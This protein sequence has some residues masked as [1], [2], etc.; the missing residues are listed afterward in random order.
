MLEFTK[1]IKA[2]K[3]PQ[4][5]SG[6][7]LRQILSN[8]IGTAFGRDHD[9]KSI[10]DT[11]DDEE[12]Y[13]RYVQNIPPSEYEAFRPYVDRSLAGE[14]DILFPG[15]PVMY[16]TTSGT[17][18]APKWLPISADYLKNVYGVMTRMWIEDMLRRRPLAFS[19]RVIAIT[20]A[21]CEGMSPDGLP[22]GS[23]SGFTRRNAPEFVKRRYAFPSSVMSISDYT[24]RYYVMMRMSV[25]YDVTFITTANPSTIVELLNNSE[26]YFDDYIEDIEA[27]TI[28]SKMDI[29]PEIRMK[30]E[31]CVSPNPQ[32][33]AFLR[34]IRL[35]YGLKIHPKHYWPNLQ[36]LSTWKC[37]NTGVFIQKFYNAFPKR[38]YHQDC[39][40]YS[41][42]CRFGIP[43]S[44]SFNTVLFP[45]LHFYEFVEESEIGSENPHFLRVHELV[46]G[47]RY[48]P[49]I[50]TVSGLYRY[51]MND[52]V[53]AGPK[54]Q[55]THTLQMVQK[56]NGIINITGEKLY[57]RQFLD[58]VRSAEAR[59][60]MG[61]TFFIGFAD[62][63]DSTYD[64]Y[65]EFDRKS[66]AREDVEHFTSIVDEV[67]MEQ[68]IEYKCK[69]ESNRLKAPR[70]WELVHRSYE[71]YKVGCLKEGRRDGQFKVVML[72]QDETKHEKFKKL[73]RNVK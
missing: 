50:T 69:R 28:S 9:F 56:I 34:N 4:E 46:Q 60:G 37:G 2:C 38:I 55:N 6:K 63:A 15:R 22:Y 53:K 43:V 61:V 3:T 42:E 10:L 59:T 66:V 29:E 68:N 26:E 27:G 67:L 12:M 65:F 58:A 31:S 41:S 21:D 47:R 40:Y 25:E 52:L 33:A 72:M 8:S 11:D 51:N 7:T 17:T 32:R 35:R 30:L 49:Y 44:D 57:E 24:A 54:Y 70:G 16:A 19:G 14:S 13:R 62:V 36:I 20:G 71:K 18:N 23:V 45:N 48:C 73:V 5:S 39:G 1:L 64:F